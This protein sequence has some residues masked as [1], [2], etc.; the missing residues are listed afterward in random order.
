MTS[1]FVVGMN[2]KQNFI[3]FEVYERVVE[4]YKR[5]NASA[6]HTAINLQDIDGLRMSEYLKEQPLSTSSMTSARDRGQSI[7]IPIKTICCLAT[8]SEH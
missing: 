1:N 5:E 4:P 2:E 8:V 7:N 3:D 6:W